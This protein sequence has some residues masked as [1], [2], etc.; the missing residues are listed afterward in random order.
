MTKDIF[1]I[2]EKDF[3]LSRQQLE[4]IVKGFDQ[5]YKMGLKTPSKGLATM[6]PSFVTKMPKGNETG[7]F[8]SLDMGG[9]NLRIA[10]VELKGAGKSTVHELKRCPSIELK[11]GEGAMFFDWI[12]DAVRDLI[13][14]EA[15]HLF[16]QD[17]VEG[18]E[19]LALGVCWSFPVDQTA[20][21]R[22][23]ILRMGKGFTL[24]NTEGNDLADM[25]HEAFKRKK[26]N[27][28]VT[29]I[30]NDT[31]GTL[32]AH[33]YTNPEC[34]IGLIFAT[35]INAAY[36]EKVSAI[37]KLDPEVRNNY[38]PTTEMLINT[39]ID[40]FGTEAYLPLT[41]Y[42]LALDLSHNQ[43][44]FQLYEKMLSG[45]YMGELTRLIAMDFI[46]AGILFGGE[47]PKGFN[48]PWSFPTTYM[49]A[50]ESDQSETKEVGQRI[51]TEFPTSEKP[52]LDDINTL[53]RIC[54]IVAAR[55]A[56]L[57]AVA[58][59]SLLEQQGLSDHMV[60]GINGS[61]YEFYP[62]MD[63]RVRQ[64]LDEW[65]GKEISS[66]I[67]LEVASEG[68]SVGGALIAMLCE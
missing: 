5:E 13:T 25:F 48:Q 55:S 59:I 62:H 17:Q 24:K 16:T 68:G 29:A 50:L 44:K 22:G 35:G 4:P 15:K 14:I 23:T 45:A 52:T 61:T 27:V 20:V 40:I 36:P 65:F 39:E 32:V 57:V 3:I 49:S 43:P 10:A 6:I 1:N 12:A 56:S 64:A 41:K 38:T 26:L 47:I 31:V 46:E 66:K 42:D 58:I 54:R 7:T 30:L 53:T 63:Q 37:T 28:K 9:T 8:L 51:L 18:K 2:I 19:T 11:T 67:I 21:D 60:V 33:A 34:R